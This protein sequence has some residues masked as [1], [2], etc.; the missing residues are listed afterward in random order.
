MTIS[1]ELTQQDQKRTYE[2]FLKY[3]PAGQKG[4]WVGLLFCELGYLTLS[5]IL[6]LYLS[7]WIGIYLFVA[8]TGYI[9]I[10]GGRSW[11]RRRLIGSRFKRH[12][13]LAITT[14]FTVCL[15]EEGVSLDQP[16]KRQLWRWTGIHDCRRDFE[17]ISFWSERNCQ[18]LIPLTVFVDQDKAE[19]FYHFA[20]SRINKSKKCFNFV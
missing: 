8:G 9:L 13:E 18:L 19:Q 20:E 5:I 10:M 14:P 12:P 6:A 3:T 1:F 17:M 2:Y 4:V 16:L 7:L 15:D 11:M